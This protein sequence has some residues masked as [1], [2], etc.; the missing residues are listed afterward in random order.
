MHARVWE[1]PP[2]VAGD[3]AAYM[4]ARFGN[5]SEMIS[6]PEAMVKGAE[7]SAAEGDALFLLKDEVR[8]A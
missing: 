6:T 5:P 2:G 8:D 7:R 1:I 4:T 3:F